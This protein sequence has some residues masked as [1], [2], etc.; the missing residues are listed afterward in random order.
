MRDLANHLEQCISEQMISGNPGNSLPSRDV[1]EELT[2]YLLSDTQVSSTSDELSLMSRVN[3]LCCLLQKDGP[4]VQN[5]QTSNNHESLDEYGP[6]ST[7]QD[8]R[9]DAAVLK[10]QG[11]SRKESFGDLLLHLPRIASLPQFLFNI[12]EED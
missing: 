2:Q 11:I 7:P 4:T 9:N 3:S 1:L 8:D 5:L 12:S 6:H 10:Q